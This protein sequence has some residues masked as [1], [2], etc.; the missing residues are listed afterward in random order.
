[1]QIQ[2]VY[3][4]RL[5][6]DYVALPPRVRSLV[7]KRIFQ[8]IS[9]RTR[10]NWV[11]LFCWRRNTET[12]LHFQRVKFEYQS[13]RPFF[14]NA[15]TGIFSEAIFRVISP[16]DPGVHWLLLTLSLFP[17]IGTIYQR[18]PFLRRCLIRKLYSPL[19]WTFI[20]FKYLLHEGVQIKK[21]KSLIF[22]NEI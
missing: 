7:K 3:F 2:W 6:L 18:K 16:G 15:T 1:M 13:T 20:W 10:T 14:N 8:S 17:P 21:G 5:A 11:N 12:L 9:L 22:G 4:K 19:I